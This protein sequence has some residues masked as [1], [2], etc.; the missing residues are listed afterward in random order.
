MGFVSSSLICWAAS[1][2]KEYLGTFDTF[3]LG[4]EK[5][6]TETAANAINKND[7]F[8]IYCVKLVGSVTDYK[9]NQI[10]QLF[11]NKLFEF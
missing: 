3:D 4:C 1:F 8:I 6:I 7:F 9:N 11:L 2:E 5:Q 10:C